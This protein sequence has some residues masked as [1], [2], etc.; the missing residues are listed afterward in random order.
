MAFP[1][2][3]IWGS[4]SLL[5]R[6]KC[7]GKQPQQTPGL[8][9]ARKHCNQKCPHIPPI[10]IRSPIT[11]RKSKVRSACVPHPIAPQSID[12]PIHSSAVT[13]SPMYPGSR[14]HCPRPLP[15]LLDHPNPTYSG[16][17]AIAVQGGSNRRCMRACKLAEKASPPPSRDRGGRRM[18]RVGRNGYP[19]HAFPCV[20]YLS[21]CRPKPRA[22]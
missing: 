4:I 21:K 2:P 13:S 19:P 7:H 14:C 10:P 11:R 17:Y 12:H 5:T 1:L 9:I 15:P 6:A 18:S 3:E 22:R 20:P 8:C 16:P